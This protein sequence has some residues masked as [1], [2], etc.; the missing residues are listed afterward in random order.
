MPRLE[1]IGPNHH[2]QPPVQQSIGLV[3]YFSIIAALI[4][5]CEGYA[6]EHLHGMGEIEITLLERP[7]QFPRI[8]DDFIP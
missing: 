2:D 4:A 7:S 3:A 1:A 6:L 8:E 5:L